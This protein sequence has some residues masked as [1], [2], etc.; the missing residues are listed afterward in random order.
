M[1]KK[2]IIIVFIALLVLCI[3]KVY[4]RSIYE[5]TL[6]IGVENSNNDKT[7]ILGIGDLSNKGG[8]R[9]N[10]STGKMQYSHNGSVWSDLGTGSGTTDHS[11]LSNLDYANA[12]HIGFEPTVTKG[13][14]TESTSSVLTIGSGT[15]A[16]IGSGTTIQVKQSSAVQDGYLSSVDWSTFN[17]KLSS[18][19]ESDPIFGLSVAAAISQDNV[20]YWNAKQEALTNPVTG[21]GIANQIAYFNG[22]S[23]ILGN[24]QFT[25]DNTNSL[26]QIGTSTSSSQLFYMYNTNVFYKMPAGETSYYSVEN[27]GGTRKLRRVYDSAVDYWTDYWTGGGRYRISVVAKLAFVSDGTQTLLYGNNSE[28]LTLNNT[29]AVINEASADRDFRVE[30][31]N[32]THTIFVDAG[33]DRVGINQ[34][35]PLFPLDIVG[36]TNITGAVFQRGIYCG[37]HVHDGTTAQTIAN[38]TTYEKITAFTD[39]DMSSNCTSDNNNDRL[40]VTKAGKYQINGSFSF[41]GSDNTTW[42]CAAFVGDVEDDSIHFRRKVSTGTDIGAASFTGIITAAVNNNVDMRCRH[43]EIAPKDLTINYGNMSINYLGE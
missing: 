13:N 23:E 37:L 24:S 26:L 30:S 11:A 41:G 3:T 33:N 15:G 40:V 14:L 9:Y 1:D 42:R 17:N 31:N 16:V 5:D 19:T 18:F 43:D 21:T 4:A 27:A 7:I 2:F 6:N 34:S 25:W 10:Y 12:N 29:E 35:T 38:G 20:N 8:L 28:L 32:A 22:T 36:N 39:A